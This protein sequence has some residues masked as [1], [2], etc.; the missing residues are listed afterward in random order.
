MAILAGGNPPKNPSGPSSPGK[1]PGGGGIP[2]SGGKPP[3]GTSTPTLV[4]PVTRTPLGGGRPPMGPAGMS[5]VDAG[6]SGTVHVHPTPVDTTSSLGGAN[7]EG[8]RMSS[9][10]TDTGYA[11]GHHR[12]FR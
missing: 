5:P 10:A 8:H 4:S 9:S 12:S 3:T 2:L 11:S 7:V 1:G 6:G